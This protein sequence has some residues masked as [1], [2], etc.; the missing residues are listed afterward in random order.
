M[1]KTLEG[2]S[3]KV[4]LALRLKSSEEENVGILEGSNG[5]ANAKF[6]G[7]EYT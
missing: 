6:P 1:V 3:E 4:I 7:W 2:L 5:I